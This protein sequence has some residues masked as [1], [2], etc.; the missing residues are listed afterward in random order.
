MKASILIIIMVLI[1][2]QVFAHS[3]NTFKHGHQRHNDWGFWQRVDQQLQDM[4]H[5]VKRG[6]KHG[7]LIPWELRKIDRMTRQTVRNL[8]Y[9][10]HRRLK[11]WEKRRV[12]NHLKAL[13]VK[14]DIYQ[15]N[16][17]W[18]KRQYPQRGWQNRS[19]DDS[20]YTRRQKT[21]YY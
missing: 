1:T 8:D 2:G 13:A 10:R 15:N 7:D 3:D 6:V 18:A 16:N 21:G 19:F 17:A 11:S 9:Y 4:S 20:K 12:F 14:I 5:R